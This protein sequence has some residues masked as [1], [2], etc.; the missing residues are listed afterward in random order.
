MLRILS[1]NST[2][3]CLQNTLQSL[4]PS[5]CCQAAC[6]SSYADHDVAAA[7]HLMSCVTVMLLSMS[8]CIAWRSGSRLAMT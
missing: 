2:S 3:I 6:S 5:S 1:L 4:A 8:C 7:T